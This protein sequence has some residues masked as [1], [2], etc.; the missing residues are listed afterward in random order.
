M[1]R[2]FFILLIAYSTNAFAEIEVDRIWTQGDWGMALVTYT[3]KTGKAIN[4][5]TIKCI[6]IG[7]GKKKLGVQ[8]RI[9]S[10]HLRGSPLEP[11][12]SDTVEVPVDLHGAKMKSMECS[13]RER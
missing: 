7:K 2:W 9:F 13:F 8:E 11:G 6:A 5:A 10:V 3:N 1:N 12:F 4:T